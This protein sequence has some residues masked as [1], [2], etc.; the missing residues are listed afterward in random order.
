MNYDIERIDQILKIQFKSIKKGLKVNNFD[1]Y[2]SKNAVVQPEFNDK[3]VIT[4]ES[5]NS[6]DVATYAC[7]ASNEHGYDYK[8]GIL[9]ER[10]WVSGCLN[11]LANLE[12]N[13]LESWIQISNFYPTFDRVSNLFPGDISGYFDH[14]S[15][16]HRTS[17]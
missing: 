5:M 10:G 14:A 17:P 8:V 3:E 7:N 15:D 16:D 4:I 11:A 9:F 13:K 1:F 6:S 2:R 12:S